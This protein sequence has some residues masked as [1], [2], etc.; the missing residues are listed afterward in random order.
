MARE[1][2]MTLP[3]RGGHRT[4][5]CRTVRRPLSTRSLG[6]ATMILWS[7]GL[8]IAPGL[9]ANTPQ[10]PVLDHA[11]PLPGAPQTAA[12]RRNPHKHPTA[13]RRFVLR[14]LSYAKRRPKL[15]TV[16]DWPLSGER[17]RLA[18]TPGPL[19]D[20]VFV[21]VAVHGF[22]KAG[23]EALPKT[24]KMAVLAETGLAGFEWGLRKAVT[25]PIH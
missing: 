16:G 7:S 5:L 21:S 23:G 18:D 20:H 19:T 15:F 1:H 2:S 22:G 12:D 17:L 6:L 25:P 8:Q 13:A 11:E 14:R 10:R 24:L 3:Y 9:P 4:A